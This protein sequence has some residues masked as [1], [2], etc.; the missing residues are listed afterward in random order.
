MPL[1]NRIALRHSKV[2]ESIPDDSFNMIFFT[3]IIRIDCNVSSSFLRSVQVR[4]LTLKLPVHISRTLL[5]IDL[6]CIK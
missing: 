4:P 3:N 6:N 5:F 1:G 2:S